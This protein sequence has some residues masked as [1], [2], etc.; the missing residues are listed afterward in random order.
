MQRQTAEV[1]LFFLSSE[2]DINTVVVVW[3]LLD[4]HN[5]GRINQEQG[6]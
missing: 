5:K 2:F 4:V 3:L 1:H 6:I